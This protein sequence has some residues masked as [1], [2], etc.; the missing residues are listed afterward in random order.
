MNLT[1]IVYLRVS[2]KDETL[3]DLETQKEA[4]LNRF[5]LV[6]PIILQERGSAFKLDNVKN[7]E[8]F[9]K[10]LDI[11][12]DSKKTTIEDLFTQNFEKKEINIYIWDYNRIMR[13]IQY[14]LLFSLLCMCFNVTIHSFRDGGRIQIQKDDPDS[15]VISIMFDL[16]SAKRAED[17]SRDISKNTKK[18]FTKRLN[19]TYSIK[20]NKKVGR[21]FTDKNGNIVNISGK[22]ED[23]MYKRVCERIEWCENNKMKHYYNLIIDHIEKS[24]KGIRLSPSYLSNIKQELTGKENGN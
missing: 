2:K 6:D 3:Q 11:S 20:N 17:Y 5:N 7:R 9:L 13:N 10:L 16:L 1:N 8:M 24:F 15:K 4:V 18:S 12:F 21:K 23:L 22:D 14:N 19:S